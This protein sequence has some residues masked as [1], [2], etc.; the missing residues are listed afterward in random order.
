MFLMFLCKKELYLR[1]KTV[2]MSKWSYFMSKQEKG[3]D[4]L[5]RPS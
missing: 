2:L 5:L 4:N 1:K 3:N